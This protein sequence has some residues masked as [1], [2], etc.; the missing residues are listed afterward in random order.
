MGI[1][2]SGPLSGLLIL[3]T[4]SLIVTAAVLMGIGMAMLARV[5][6]G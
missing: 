2:Q 1:H 6:A 4:V 5:I 3:I